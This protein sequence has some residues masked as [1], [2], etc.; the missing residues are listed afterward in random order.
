MKFAIQV[1]NPTITYPHN[2]MVSDLAEAI[3]T[4]FPMNTEDAFLLW[5]LVPIRLNYKY[6]VSV[7]IDDILPLLQT[8]LSQAEGN[9]QVSWG[10]DTFQA[11]W[12]LN[13]SQDQLTIQTV[14]HQVTGH[15]EDL[16]NSRPELVIEYDKFL[17]EWDG[18]LRKVSESLYRVGIKVE[19]QDQLSLL[20]TIQGKL[21]GQTFWR[22]AA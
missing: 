10:S 12:S 3:E 5:N 8:M 7:L 1:C 11:D 9:Y 16:L 14:W 15:Y 19:D 2:R 17:H 20:Y 21:A 13:W 18:L 4:I 6:D 22:M